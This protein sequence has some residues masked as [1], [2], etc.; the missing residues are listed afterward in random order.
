MDE[1]KKKSTLLV[2]LIL[3]AVVI[4]ITVGS[5]F[6]YFSV[7]ISSNENA[8]SMKAA[9]FRIDFEDDISLIKGNVIPSEERFV[10]IAAK[11]VDANGF[12]KPYEDGEG[13]LIS[14]G[15]VCIDDNLNEICSVY[16]FTLK[17]PMTDSEIPLYITLNPS[18][19]NF[20]NL[21]FKVL[22]S[23]LN[24]VIS[25]THLVDDRPYTLD[26]NDNKIYEANSVISP[27]VLTN[28]NTTLPKATDSEHPS[29]VTYS[30]VLW[31]DETFENQNASDGGKIFAA[32]LN[33]RA[34][35][36]NGGGITG[37]ISA[38]GTDG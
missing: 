23:E 33:A 28:I 36:A 12:K 10:D 25:K 30:I 21:Y 9:E 15:T 26:E 11:R 2:F 14:D 27:I 38:A 29:S 6:A 24:E 19:N 37:V 8:V 35:G 13:H 31:I 16:T 18:M 5:T 20:E 3:I 34:S 1:N 17:N 32:T 22:D 4:L 7:T